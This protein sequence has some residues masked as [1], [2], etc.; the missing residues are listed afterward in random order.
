[1]KPVSA[2]VVTRQGSVFIE[3]ECPDHGS[4]SLLVSEDAK[5]YQELQDYYFST[6]SQSIP[7]TEYYMHVTNRCNMN[8]PMC[9]LDFS[10]NGRELSLDSVQKL[11]LDK[12][13]K[14]IT[15]SHSEATTCENLPEIVKALHNFGKI[16]NIHTNGIKLADSNYASSLKSSGIHHISLQFD[17]FNDKAYINLR[18]GDFLDIKLKALDNLKKLAIPVTLNATIAKG[19]NEDEV[20]KIFDFA[21]RERFIKDISFITY[22][23]YERNNTN[24]DKYLMPQELL[25][26]IDK[27]TQGKI[28]RKA[29]YLF[30][31]VFFA[32][33]SA[34]AKR[35]CF[36]YYHYLVLRRAGGYLGVDEILDLNRACRYLER[37]K[38]DGAR[39]NRFR[40]LVLLVCSMKIKSLFM[41]PL[42]LTM[43]FRGG[44]PRKPGRLLVIT[45][46]TICDPYK[47][48]SQIARNCGQGILGLETPYDSYG[49][50]LMTYMIKKDSY[51][52]SKI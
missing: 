18:G 3:K 21:L 17:G 25:K 16:V 29:I 32:Y 24:A 33:C 48:D 8:C 36:Y 34:F 37:L 28:S 31:K 50:F 12:G 10:G 45:F 14:R 27:H 22:S 9:F 51:S 39:V 49:D 15:F 41:F 5:D 42:S 6:V 2:F 1:M 19:V 35:K 47:Y 46:A 7:Q 11:A 43:L 40:F 13:V 23:N 30:Q 38:S 52:K 4:F 20:G 26:N 44:F